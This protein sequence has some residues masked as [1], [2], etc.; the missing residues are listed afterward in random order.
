MQLLMKHLSR[1][2]FKSQAGGLA[3]MCHSGAR[4]GSEGLITK[5]CTESSSFTCYLFRVLSIPTSYM[6]C[7]G[8]NSWPRCQLSWL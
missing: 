2:I 5:Q 7:P 8:F 3:E 1:R 4:A 6:G